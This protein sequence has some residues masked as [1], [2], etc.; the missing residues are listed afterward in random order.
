MMTGNIL[1]SI[2]DDVDDDDNISL[3]IIGGGD[4][5]DISLSIIG[6]GDGDDAVSRNHH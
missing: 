3:S 5:D 6:G 4:G 1:L 2:N